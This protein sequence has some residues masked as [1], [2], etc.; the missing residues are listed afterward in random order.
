MYCPCCS[1]ELYK[2]HKPDAAYPMLFCHHDGIVYDV[3]RNTWYGITRLPP[4]VRCPGCGQEMDGEPKGA[5]VMHFCFECG[6]T[7]DRLKNTWYGVN[8]RKDEG[9]EEPEEEWPQQPTR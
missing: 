5:A 9:T 8:M 1:I 6:I 2:P 7:Y 4:I 3:K